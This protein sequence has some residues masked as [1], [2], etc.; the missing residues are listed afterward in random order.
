VIASVTTTLP[1]GDAARSLPLRLQPRSGEAL[2]SWLEALAHR[3]RT[4]WSDMLSA[5]GLQ[6][7]LLRRDHASWLVKLTESELDAIAAVTGVH[8]AGLQS[9]TLS[10]FDGALDVEESRPLAT[11]SSP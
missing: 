6:Q 10:R 1:V 9:M 5:V 4:R 3:H 8:P 11:Q 2:D 7:D